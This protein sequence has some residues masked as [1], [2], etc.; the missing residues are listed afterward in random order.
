MIFELYPDFKKLQ[1]VP[2]ARM[3][4]QWIKDKVEPYLKSL[5]EGLDI[6]TEDISFR[7]KQEEIH[8]V[9]ESKNEEDFWEDQPSSS[10]L[11]RD[12]TSASIP[13]PSSSP[14]FRCYSSLTERCAAP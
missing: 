3:E 9:K 8:G 1:S 11:R 13:P 5:E 2:K 7:K 14:P 10:Y 6:R 4:E 12:S